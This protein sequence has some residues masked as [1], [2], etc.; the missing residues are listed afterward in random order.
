MTQGTVALNKE[1]SFQKNIILKEQL[2]S[3][4][5]FY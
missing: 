1:V 3:L 2:I 5:R 4:V